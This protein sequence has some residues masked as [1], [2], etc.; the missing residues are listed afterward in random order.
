M[1]AT[2]SCQSEHAGIH[3]SKTKSQVVIHLI[4]SNNTARRLSYAIAPLPHPIT[5][6]VTYDI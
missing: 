4:P 1:F 6:E 5:F 2:A 3:E